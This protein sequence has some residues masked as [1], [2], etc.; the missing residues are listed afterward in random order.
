MPVV[1]RRRKD[2]L[3]DVVLQVAGRADET[4]ANGLVAASAERVRHAAARAMV[5]ARLD[6]IN[7]RERRKGTRRAL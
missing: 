2:G 5:L 1:K 4:L 6:K 3:Y 7:R